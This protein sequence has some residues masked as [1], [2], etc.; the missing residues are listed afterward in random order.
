MTATNVHYDQE[1]GL[2]AAFLDRTLKYSAGLFDGRDKSL[3]DA[4]R[5][6]LAF[7][8]SQLR[9]SGG[10]TVLDIGCG[11]GALVCDL[12]ARL[13][14]RATGIT[15][16]PRQAEYIRRRAAADRIADRVDVHIG[17]IEATPLADGAFDAVSLLGSI[18]HMPDKAG[19][20]A[21]CRRLLRPGGQLYLSE[22]CFRNGAIQREFAERPGTRFVRDDIFGWGELIPLSRYIQLIEDAGLSPAAVID[23]TDDYRRTIEKW[24]DNAVA[25]RD[26]IDAHGAGMCDRLLRY[27]DVSNA[28]WG[29]TTK[30]YAVVARR[31]R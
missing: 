13:D 8:A 28:G 17:T 26:R 10:E 12:A 27:F 31:K 24:R 9:L 20:L 7:V 22:S 2:F 19:V 1:A 6:K 11:W 21:R 30:H 4:Q 29:Y 16:S 5:D 14:C 3:D 15:P 25:A 18:V 23:L